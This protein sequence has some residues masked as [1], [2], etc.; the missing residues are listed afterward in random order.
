MPLLFISNPPKLL[1]NHCSILKGTL[2]TPNCVKRNSQELYE[3]LKFMSNNIKNGYMEQ[4]PVFDL[5]PEDGNAWWL[6]IFPVHHPK[7]GKMSYL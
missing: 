3:A 6:S 1:N 4:V 2:N 7:K 5:P